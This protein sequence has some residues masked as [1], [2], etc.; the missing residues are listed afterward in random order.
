V[1]LAPCTTALA[2]HLFSA[3]FLHVPLAAWHLVCVASSLYSAFSKWSFVT[4]APSLIAPFARCVFS[5]WRPIPHGSFV[6][7]AP[8]LLGALFR[9]APL[10]AWRL[11]YLAPYSA[12]LLCLPG[13]WSTRRVSAWCLVFDDCLIV[14]CFLVWA[15]TAYSRGTGLFA[16]GS[17]PA[18]SPCSCPKVLMFLNISW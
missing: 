18:A 7:L 8:G 5:P 14:G 12:W 11:V 16:G 9:M 13:A 2:E 4:L 15:C 10:S 3:P 6:C 17:G 1:R